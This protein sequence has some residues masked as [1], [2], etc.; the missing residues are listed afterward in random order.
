MPLLYS[1]VCFLNQYLYFIILP[2]EIMQFN[3][4]NLDKSMVNTIRPTD[5]SPFDFTSRFSCVFY[6]MVNNAIVCRDDLA[7]SLNEIEGIIEASDVIRYFYLGKQ[8]DQ[9]IF[10]I[11]LGDS[12]TLSAAL[13]K[14]NDDAFSLVDLREIAEKGADNAST[15]SILGYAC[16]LNYWLSRHSYCSTCG[17]KMSVALLGHAQYCPKDNRFFY[18]RINSA[19]I[20]QIS[21]EN[22]LFLARQ[23]KWPE[24]RYSVVAGFVE[25]GESLEQT[26]AREIK[27]ETNLDVTNI[28][29]FASQPW[30]FPNSAMIGFTAE[31]TSLNFSIDNDE[32][33]DA[34][35]L[36][37]DEIV[38][39]VKAGSL[40]TPT[41]ISISFQLIDDW[42]IKQT[43]KS[44]KQNLI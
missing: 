39:R 21:H 4:F 25:P 19:V 13:S 24:K 22:Q 44:L 11:V 7:L 32:L 16:H 10:F 5:S 28:R 40:L 31:A 15:V 9:Q 38:S 42:I 33:S 1:R 8:D 36:T 30:P 37:A 41:N 12:S 23:D 27:E 29:Y 43:G 3:Q 2:E 17:S 18:P 14:E 20:V 26:V 35:W 34:M 6:F